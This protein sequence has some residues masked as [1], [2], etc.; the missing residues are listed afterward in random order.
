MAK[1]MSQ[2]KSEKLVLPGPDDY[3]EPPTELLAYCMMIYGEKGVGKTSLASRFPNAVVGMLEPR[4]RN[5]KI[6]QIYLDSWEKVQEYVDLVIE[7]DTVGTG[8]I[9]T[10][11]RAYDHCLAYHCRIRGIKD[12]S[13]LNDYGATWRAIKDDFE[14]TFNK[15]LFA[16]K[17][18]VFISHAHLRE[19]EVRTGEKYEFLC[20]TSSPAAF[21]YVKA[22]ADYAFYMGYHNRRRAMYLR[23]H[24]DLWCACGT[25]DFFLDPEGKEVKTILLG[26]NP[27]AA[28][29]TLLSSF[30]NKV[31][32]A[33]NIPEERVV[34]KKKVTNG[35]AKNG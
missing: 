34:K 17:G 14:S 16:E 20:P 10:I 28:F 1:K 9:D 31:W 33:D 22:V 18:L 2:P 15:I 5:L 23:G 24:E 32:D 21:K 3:N 4:R 7:D 29:D 6:R 19:A 35:D 11:D 27:D 30:N 25:S 26:E 12:P 8:V 13:D